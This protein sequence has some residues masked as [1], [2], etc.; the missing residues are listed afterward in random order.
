MAR[1]NFGGTP[2]TRAG[3][4]RKL[5]LRKSLRQRASVSFSG[6]AWKNEEWDKLP[7]VSST[8][9]FVR[10]I[11][12]YLGLGEEHF[13][14]NTTGVRRARPIKT[15]ARTRPKTRRRIPQTPLWIPSLSWA[16]SFGGGDHCFGGIYGWRRFV[17]TPPKSR[18]RPR[19]TCPDSSPGCKRFPLRPP[20][21]LRFRPSP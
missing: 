6:S 16:R 18:P 19:G 1:G 9:G 4:A 2:K 7:A 21:P 8:A 15:G 20:L 14:P 12:H 11:A 3:I 13:L 10:S 5:R 17:S